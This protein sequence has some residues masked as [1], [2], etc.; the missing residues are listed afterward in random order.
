MTTSAPP[1]RKARRR[2]PPPAGGWWGEGPS[3]VERWPGVTIPITGT[4]VPERKRWESHAGMYYYDQT[5]ADKAVDFFPELLRH[6]IGEWAGQP[7]TLLDY[8]ALLLTRP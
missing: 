8:Q 6:H 2:P 3:P 1:R 4:W 5:A 7:F